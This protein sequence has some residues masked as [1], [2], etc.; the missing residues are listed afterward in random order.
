MWS[1]DELLA[2]RANEALFA[3]AQ[4]SGPSIHLS[5]LVLSTVL[6]LGARTDAMANLGLT[7][8]AVTRTDKLPGEKRNALLSQLLSVIKSFAQYVASSSIPVP[9][10]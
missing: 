7:L 3:I 2:Q 1:G 10:L 6:R 5:Q 9:D 8:P 4:Q